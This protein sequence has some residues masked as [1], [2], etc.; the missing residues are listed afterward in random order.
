MKKVM[1]IIVF[2]MKEKQTFGIQ[3]VGR[4]NRE[5]EKHFTIF[6]RITVNGEVDVPCNKFTTLFC[7]KLIRIMT[8][9]GTVIL[10]L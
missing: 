2:D 1:A 10:P 8:G 9:G 3:F 5:K 6:A 4:K 7:S